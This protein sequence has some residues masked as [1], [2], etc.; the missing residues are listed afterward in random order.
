MRDLYKTIHKKK[1]DDSF[2][3]SLPVVTKSAQKH[4]VCTA[5]DSPDP[6][7]Q[8]FQVTTS[9]VCGLPKVRQVMCL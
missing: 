1:K 8:W 5:E 2:G 4:D 7:M 6:T 9:Y 3:T